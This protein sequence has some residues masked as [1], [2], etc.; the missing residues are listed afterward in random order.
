MTIYMTTEAFPS[1]SVIVPTLNEGKFIGN[2]LRSLRNQ[3][4]E[5]FETIII[6]GGSKD[7]TLKIA[8][9][10][11]AKTVVKPRTP[12]FQSRNIGAKMARGE[13]LLF[14]SADVIFRT[15]T[16]QRVVQEFE[17]DKSLGAVCGPGRLYNAPLWARIEYALYYSLLG[18]YTK[19]T[20]DFNGSTNFM[21]VKKT[22]FSKIGGFIERIDADGYFLNEVGSISKVKFISNLSIPIS[23]RRAEKMGFIGFN[24]HFL[25][26]LDAFFPFSRETRII[27]T[28][29]NY[30]LNYRKKQK[31]A[32]LS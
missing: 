23:G 8:Y 14:T 6:D 7:E 24:T 18:I 13:I 11:K 4:Y 31:S 1:V 27:R 29:E 15:D 9:D 21:A 20:K 26:A 12:E 32:A 28:L 17:N 25:Y 5:N 2:L 16:I 30:S 19:V 22:V 3:T 10:F